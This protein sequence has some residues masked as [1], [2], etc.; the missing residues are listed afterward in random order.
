MLSH[1]NNILVERPP[2]GTWP[3][4][5]SYKLRG[6]GLVLFFFLDQVQDQNSYSSLAITKI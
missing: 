2:I 4:S 5:Y 3:C 1:D 6:L